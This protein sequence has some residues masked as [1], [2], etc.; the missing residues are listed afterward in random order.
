MFGMP[1]EAK[2]VFEAEE[3]KIA[4]HPSPT[5]AL[6]LG[7]SY[8]SL[9]VLDRAEQNFQRALDLNPAC[10]LATRALPRLRSGK[11]Y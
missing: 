7:K 11:G 9:G 8:L 1:L 3:A 5:L 4:E 10:A 2:Q 6:Q